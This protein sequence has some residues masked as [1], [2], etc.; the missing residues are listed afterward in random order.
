MGEAGSTQSSVANEGCG[1]ADEGQEV[2]CL[3]FVAAVESAAAREPGHGPLYDPAMTA[4]S[5]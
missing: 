3:A 2:L 1:Y 4:E 5:L